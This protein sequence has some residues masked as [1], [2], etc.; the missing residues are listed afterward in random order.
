MLGA[1]FSAYAVTLLGRCPDPDLPT[2]PDLHALAAI[3]AAWHATRQR[4]APRRIVAPWSLANLIVGMEL[5]A[6]ASSC[7]GQSSA[8]PRSPHLT[9]D[10]HQWPLTGQRGLGG[11]PFGEP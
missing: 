10:L 1:G 11:H 6:T 7:A 3:G 4:L 8:P 9:H 5:M 2:R